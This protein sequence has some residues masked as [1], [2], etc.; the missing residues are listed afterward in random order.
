[1]RKN[2]MILGLLA[3]I[4]IISGCTQSNTINIVPGTQDLI[5]SEQDL[6]QLGMTSDLNEQ[7]LQ[8]LGLS[9]GTN[10]RT[11]ESYTNIADSS[12]GQYSICAYLIPSLNDTQVIIELKKFANYE[13]LN[14]TY[15]YESSHLYSVQGLISEND[16][17]D[18]SRFRV[19]N[20][21]DYGG[22]FNEPGVYYYHLWVA[23]GL[24]L[25]H[26]TSKGAENAKDYIVR[27]GEQ[28]L[29]KFE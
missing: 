4:I 28:F 18:Q 24:Y 10:C 2:F 9:T 17:G 23:K 29:S 13:A 7:D 3:I 20:E 22:Q 16:F 15:Q 21:N 12:L 8:Q 27:T 5:L 26:I 6:Q 25:I 19:N 11:E 1:M 14:N